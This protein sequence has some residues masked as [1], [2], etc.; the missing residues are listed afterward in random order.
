V[1]NDQF[2]SYEQEQSKVNGD[3]HS[4][5]V[6]V[7]I[8]IE[9]NQNVLKTEEFPS[10]VFNTCEDSLDNS[11]GYGVMLIIICHPLRCL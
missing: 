3:D 11:S 10:Q 2:F 6:H 9:S 7:R 1:L 4:D 8:K 5:Q